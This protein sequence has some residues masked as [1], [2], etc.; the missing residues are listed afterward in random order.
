MK[1][2][3]FGLR[4]HCWGGLGSQLFAANLAFDM[5]AKFPKK[6]ITI[7]LHSGG[8]TERLPEL[9]EVFPNFNYEIIDDFSE[10][11]PTQIS[12]INVSRS[13]RKMLSNALYFFRL[14][15][16]LND[17]DTLSS[18]KYWTIA[19]RGHY[20]YRAI[21][22][23]FLEKFYKNANG[24]EF[25]ALN[26]DSISLHYRLGDLMSLEEKGPIDNRRVIQVIH[27]VGDRL[28]DAHLE[29]YSDSP[30]EALLLLANS[31]LDLAIS[32]R[33]QPPL[34]LIVSCSNSKY[35]VGTS[36]KISFWVALV[37]SEILKKDSYL[38][39]EKKDEFKWLSRTEKLIHYY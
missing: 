20:S 12:S 8:V 30:R 21:S 35:F 3:H 1:Y 14:V 11:K 16:T 4:I 17:D 39:R 27:L 25:Q 5:Q 23:E 34:Q 31:D 36:S 29:L 22:H 33:E 10:K 6:N 19:V 7:V 2:P 26:T 13:L 24:R 18:F 9:P 38:P 32:V 37:R 15:V 28:T